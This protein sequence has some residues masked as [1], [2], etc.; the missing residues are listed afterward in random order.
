MNALTGK[1]W[2]TKDSYIQRRMR[3]KQAPVFINTQ[4][5]VTLGSVSGGESPYSARTR[6]RGSGCHWS[7]RCSLHKCRIS[8]CMC[9]EENTNR[10]VLV[11]A[12]MIQSW[13]G[14]RIMRCYATHACISS[15]KMEVGEDIP[16]CRIWRSYSKEKWNSHKRRNHCN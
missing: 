6:S 16:S 9:H 8:R 1:A 10:A 5:E 12:K 2:H 13:L 4:K 15:R 14:Q 11:A 3:A 7:S